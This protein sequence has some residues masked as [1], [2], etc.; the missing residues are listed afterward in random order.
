MEVII[1]IAVAIMFSFF[2][3]FLKTYILI[4]RKNFIE[5][6]IEK[7]KI[8]A[9]KEIQ[10]RKKKSDSEIE[11]K[12][13]ELRNREKKLSEK[14]DFL[15][16]EL[17]KNSEKKEIIEEKEKKVFKDLEQISGITKNQALEQIKKKIEEENKQDLF[18]SMRKLEGIKKESLEERAKEI[19]ALSIQ[20]YSKNLENNLVTSSIKIPEDEKGKIIGKEGRN[21][22]SF[23]K[24]T[25]VQ[26][27]VD[28][29][30]NEIIISSFDP[31]RR[32]V[33]VMALEELLKDGIIHPGKIEDV[34]KEARE[35]IIK[36]IQKAGADAAEQVGL[37]NTPKE[38]L[39]IIGRLHFRSSYGQNVLKHSIEMA[40][41]AEVMAYELGA[42]VYVAKA[43]ALFHDIGKAVD[44]ETKGT[45]VEIGIKILRKNGVDEEIIKAMQTH[46][47]EY[48]NENLES[49][50]VDAA[51]AI[52]GARPG[53]RSDNADMYIKK[54]EG[55]EKITKEFDG[56]SSAYALS[57]GR[58]VRVF[59]KPDEVDDI[60]AAKM[61]RDIAVRIEEELK[62]PGEI[63]IAVIR[64]QKVVEFAR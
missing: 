50:I 31:I 34:V 29:N 21:I 1:Y 45:H 62:Y 64:E 24:E 18:V 11:E 13:K 38:V 61:A 10:E 59:V 19:I 23:E 37:F 4:K 9:E 44:F 20:K 32:E 30:Q 51:D 63:K 35:N 48:P 47:R 55:L 42:D 60:D 41:I 17:K 7:K 43:G 5:I 33:A 26:L 40:H 22:K 46:H 2:G 3:Y 54:L 53:A 36:T 28:Q 12:N 14:D 58:E 52:S 15:I 25:G 57:A 27:I 16:K 39:D 8:G 56:V 6:E 49:Y